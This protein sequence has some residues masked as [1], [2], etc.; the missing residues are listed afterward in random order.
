MNVL[1]AFNE[2]CTHQRLVFPDAS[3]FKSTIV[4]YH[5]FT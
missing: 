5:E 1:M 4:S 3:S 2:Y